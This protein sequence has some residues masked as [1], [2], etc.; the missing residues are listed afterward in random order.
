MGKS[1]QDPEALHYPSPAMPL[2]DDLVDD[3]VDDKLK[4]SRTMA[5]L[6]ALTDFLLR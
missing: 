6:N 2:A 4:T 3:L 1:K 5:E